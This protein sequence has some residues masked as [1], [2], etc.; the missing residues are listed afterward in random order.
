MELSINISVRSDKQ[1]MDP[2]RHLGLI[3]TDG[4]L[5]LSYQISD[6]MIL[7]LWLP[8]GIGEV[9]VVDVGTISTYHSTS[10]W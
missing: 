7:H 10:K 8:W 6:K 2:L 3:K 5:S 4:G 9:E 1:T